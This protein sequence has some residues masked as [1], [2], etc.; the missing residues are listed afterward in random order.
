M[1]KAIKLHSAF[2][3]LPLLLLLLLLTVFSSRVLFILLVF[4]FPCECAQKKI[5]S[6]KLGLLA[7]RGGRTFGQKLK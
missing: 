5:M 4:S 1:L 3:F 7:G 6:R 2:F